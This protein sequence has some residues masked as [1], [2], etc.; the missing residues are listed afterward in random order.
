V[1]IIVIDDGSDDGTGDWLATQ[2]DVQ[3]VQGH[4][5]GKPAGVNAATRLATGKYIRFLDSDDWL[6]ANANELQF[7]LAEQTGADVVVAGLDIYAEARH[8]ERLD[9]MPTDDFIAQ[10]LGETPGSHYSAFLF[11][12]QF[13]EDIPHRTLFPAAD[14]AAR[15]DRCFILEVALKKPRLTVCPTPTLCHRHHQRRRLQIPDGLKRDGT[16]I[17]H[18]YV[19]RQILRLLERAGELT[20]RRKQAAAKVLWR[21]A[22]WIGYTHPQEAAD[23][24]N[25]VF[26][27]DPAFLPPEPGWLGTLY[28]RLGFRKT[29]A[30]LQFRRSFLAFMQA[31]RI[32]G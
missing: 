23:V 18:L 11:R 14:F 4:G 20:T 16:H 27:L 7:E 32:V 31:L 21:L 26:Q 29:E 22:H 5:W 8:V 28:R 2:A 30:V 19:Y 17:Q 9:W 25:W 15:D 6:N 13:V 1:Q 3:V 12:R 24:A 10:Q